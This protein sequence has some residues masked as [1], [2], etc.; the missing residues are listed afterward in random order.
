[1]NRKGGEEGVVAMGIELQHSL[2]KLQGLSAVRA[3]YQPRIPPALEVA[4]WNTVLCCLCI[5]RSDNS[6]GCDEVLANFAIGR[7]M[8]CG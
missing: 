7:K 5:E 8:F 6:G 1:V 4:V 3:Q 2:S